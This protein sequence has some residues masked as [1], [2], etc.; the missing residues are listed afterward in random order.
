M[1]IEEEAELAEDRRRTRRV[2]K[3]CIRRRDES[4]DGQGRE[5]KREERKRSR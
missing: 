1:K 2:R 5:G 4:Y 3:K